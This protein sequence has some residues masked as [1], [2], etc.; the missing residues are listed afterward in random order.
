[1]SRYIMT[2]ETVK[3]KDFLFSTNKLRII[4]GAS[5]LLDYLNQVVVP[6]ILKE[7][8]VKEEDIIYIGAGN[9]KFFI[10]TEEQA[11]NIAYQVKEA[12]R[13]QAPK[14]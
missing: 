11:K 3:I 2:V 13:R 10:D 14:L 6:K 5:Y 9:A 7:N 12:Y 8:K 4:R 1:M